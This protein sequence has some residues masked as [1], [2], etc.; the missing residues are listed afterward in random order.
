M[1]GFDLTMKLS[2]VI[3]VYNEK[4]TLAEIV[5]RVQATPYEKELIIVDDASTD[6]S[7]DI[8]QQL[9]VEADNIRAFYHDRNQGKGAAL[10]TGFSKVSGDIV[11]IQDADLEYNPID[12]PELLAPIEKGLADVVFGSRLIGAAPHRVLFFWHYVGNKV[13]TTISNM[14]TNLNLTDM[15]TC[16]KVFKAEIINDIKIRSERFGVEPELTAKIA[17]KRC[18]VYEVPISYD[19]RDYSEGKKITWRDG[20]AALYYI[21]RFRFWD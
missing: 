15:E 8:L 20:I 19:G 13:V 11:I 17:R 18:R 12:Y 9:A 1:K 5:R 4:A 10:R 16:Y 2:I 14:M 3:P 6:G 21:I 7:R